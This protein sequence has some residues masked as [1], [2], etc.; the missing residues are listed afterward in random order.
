MHHQVEKRNIQKIQKCHLFVFTT[1]FTENTFS[2]TC[3]R[4][5]TKFAHCES[6]TCFYTHYVFLLSWPN[7]Q[8]MADITVVSYNTDLS[9]IIAFKQTLLEPDL[10]NLK[11]FDIVF[12]QEVGLHLYRDLTDQE[13]VFL[14]MAASLVNNI[15]GST[16]Y[17]CFNRPYVTAVSRTKF[18]RPIANL[19]KTFP[20]DVGKGRVFR[21]FQRIELSF[22]TVPGT[23]IKLRN[24]HTVSGQEWRA[25]TQTLRRLVFQQLL[26]QSTLTANIGFVI[27]AGDFNTLSEQEVVAWHGPTW[28]SVQEGAG[29]FIFAR[30]AGLIKLAL[31]FRG[32]QSHAHQPVACSIPAISFVPTK[33]KQE[34]AAL[35]AHMVKNVARA[36]ECQPQALHHALLSSLS[37][38]I[39]TK[40]QHPFSFSQIHLIASPRCH[41]ILIQDSIVHIYYIIFYICIPRGSPTQNMQAVPFSRFYK[42]QLLL[43]YRAEAAMTEECKS[44]N[45]LVLLLKQMHYST[46]QLAAV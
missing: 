38:H 9:N 6:I 18:T 28:S 11:Q 17:V 24:N 27:V 15:L 21:H 14:D 10:A 46:A 37:V 32:M 2:V 12:L 43:L 1:A 20:D 44:R 4:I 39:Q 23:K 29:D 3:N 41:S 26:D 16:H 7:P 19:I 31:P 36:F 8:S 30:H 25:A 42:Y 40:A 22:V 5:P 45:M 35:S 34:F 13:K 33:P